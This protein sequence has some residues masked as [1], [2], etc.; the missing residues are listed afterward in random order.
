MRVDRRHVERLPGIFPEAEQVRLVPHLEAPGRLRSRRQPADH[1]SDQLLPRV[2]VRRGDVLRAARATEDGTRTGRRPRFPEPDRHRKEDHERLRTEGAHPRHVGEQLVEVHFA[3]C[4]TDRVE[5]R[6]D[7]HARRDEGADVLEHARIPPDAEQRHVDRPD[8]LVEVSDDVR[9]TRVGRD[10]GGCCRRTGRCWRWRGRDG[11]RGR[12]CRPGGSGRR[13]GRRSTAIAVAGTGGTHG[14]HCRTGHPRDT[15]P[16]S[17]HALLHRTGSTTRG[18]R[19]HLRLRLTPRP[20]RC[21]A[22]ER[23]LAMVPARK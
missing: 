22:R 20:G 19:R 16:H 21:E 5:V 7:P 15:M 3:G 2:Q 6:V 12:G 1:R 10:G 23:T 13:R 17:P 11:R 8:G 18:R 9:P 4:G 14:D